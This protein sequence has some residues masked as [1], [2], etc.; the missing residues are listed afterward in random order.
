MFSRLFPKHHN[1]NAETDPSSSQND[2]RVLQTATTFDSSG[3]DVKQRR[4]SETAEIAPCTSIDANDSNVKHKDLPRSTDITPIPSSI[5][6]FRVNV[7]P[8]MV[9]GDLMTIKLNGILTKILISTPTTTASQKEK[10]V[11]QTTKDA[12]DNGYNTSPMPSRTET[13]HSSASSSSSSS[14]TP[15]EDQKKT[16]TT[17]TVSSEVDVPPGKIMVLAKPVVVIHAIFPQ[18]DKNLKDIMVDETVKE[19]IQECVHGECNAI[20]GMTISIKEKKNSSKSG[21]GYLVRCCGTPCLLLP[22]QLLLSSSSSPH[23]N[24]T[25]HGSTTTTTTNNT[26]TTGTTSTPLLR[27]RTS[28]VDEA[29]TLQRRQ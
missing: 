21:C 14:T 12:N 9:P 22:S 20:L 10:N 3:C 4:S 7:P 18:T 29:S 25:V 15:T 5:K 13:E 27:Q 8:S 24:T 23:S 11:S 19:L 1:H 17:V 28:S 16:I 6:R 2:E 26:T